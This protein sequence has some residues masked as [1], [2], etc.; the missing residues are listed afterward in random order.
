MT[1]AAA[2]GTD[3]KPTARDA[4]RAVSTGE[5]SE[6]QAAADID[7]MQMIHPLPADAV[8]IPVAL[9]EPPADGSTAAVSTLVY[10]NTLGKSVFAPSAAGSRFADDITTT[11]ANGCLLDKFTFQVSGNSDG[12]LVN[13]TPFSVEY[14]LYTSCPGATFTPVA[15]AGTT[16][17]IGVRESPAPRASSRISRSSRRSSRSNDG[18]K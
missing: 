16:R 14:A 5:A 13:P 11:G 15:I 18:S 17:A 2:V 3:V 12:S 10:S 1:V 4:E 8:V 6:V 7:L 9:G